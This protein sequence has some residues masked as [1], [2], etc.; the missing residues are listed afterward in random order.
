MNDQRRA[1]G[2]PQSILQ[3]AFCEFDVFWL[4]EA[5]SR[6]GFSKRVAGGFG[7]REE[8]VDEARVVCLHVVN[9]GGPCRSVLV[10]QF[11]RFA[12]AGGE[13]RGAGARD[14]WRGQVVLELRRKMFVEVGALGIERVQRFDVT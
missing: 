8:I 14:S 13:I 2:A 7:G 1:P 5:G 10:L 3:W 12:E 6:R 4:V 9:C 11:V